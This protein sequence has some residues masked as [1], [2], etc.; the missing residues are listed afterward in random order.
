ML[1]CRLDRFQFAAQILLERRQQAVM[2]ARF[3]C[4]TLTGRRATRGRTSHRVRDGRQRR[5]QRRCRVGL[6]AIGDLRLRV[7]LGRLSTQRRLLGLG[8]ASRARTSPCVSRLSACAHR[9]RDCRTRT[10]SSQCRSR[11]RGLGRC[12]H[13]S[14]G[15]DVSRVSASNRSSARGLRRLPQRFRRRTRGTGVGRASGG[16]RRGRARRRGRCRN[17]LFRSASRCRGTACRLPRRHAAGNGRRV[18]NHLEVGRVH[19]VG[20]RRFEHV[21]GRLTL[22][23]A[24]AGHLRLRIGFEHRRLRAGAANYVSESSASGG[25]STASNSLSSSGV[26]A[27][28]ESPSRRNCTPRSVA[29]IAL[30]NLLSCAHSSTVAFT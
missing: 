29:R 16:S 26:P 22:D 12:S 13:L 10:R 8:R 1:G 15:K 23:L 6:R 5:V 28:N 4:R 21:A 7:G 14:G 3:G 18:V 19:E 20:G 27:E 30:P 24:H 25:A 2:R 17:R 11:Q 9:L